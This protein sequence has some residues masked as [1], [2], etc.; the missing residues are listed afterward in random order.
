VLAGVLAGLA[1]LTAS[2]PSEAQTRTEAAMSDEELDRRLTFLEH[3]LQRERRRATVW[4]TTWVGVYSAGAVAQGVRMGLATTAADRA[5]LLIST[6]KAMGGVMR[7]GFMPMNGIEG[8][9]EAACEPT[10]NRADRLA[11][12]R[13]AERALERNAHREKIRN[14]WWVHLI[15]IG[16]NAA[17]AAIV[18][19]AYDAPQ[20]AAVSAGIGAGV[21]EVMLFTQPGSAP[22]DLETYRAGLVPRPR[23]APIRWQ[24]SPL[25][26]GAALSFTF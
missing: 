1:A 8:M 9:P 25:G 21:G 4:W 20:T 24:V 15:N 13:R 3:S 5:D 23:P 19:F 7:L 2:R 22:R 12:L 18:T 26:A 16:V 6:I 11:L 17:G 10:C 14:A